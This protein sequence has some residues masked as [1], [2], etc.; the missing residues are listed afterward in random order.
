MMPTKPLV[1]GAC[2]TILIAGARALLLD[3]KLTEG[4]GAVVVPLMVN[5]ADAASLVTRCSLR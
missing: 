5:C 2:A 3:G 1:A 4:A